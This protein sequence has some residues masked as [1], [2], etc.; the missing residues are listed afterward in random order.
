MEQG[1][2]ILQSAAR[3]EQALATCQDSEELR[4][5]LA[6]AAT[7]LVRRHR[8]SEAVR[9][10]DCLVEFPDLPSFAYCN[11]LWVAQ[12]DNTGLPVE[13]RRS[14]RYLAACLPYA[15][16]NPP[17]HLNAA[18]VFMELGETDAAL[19]QLLLAAS[20]RVDIQRHLAQPQLQP[21][22]AHPRWPELIA[23]QPPA[24]PEPS[25]VSLVQAA[26]AHGGAEDA[27]LPLLLLWRKTRSA[28]LADLI[29]RL[30][31]C[32]GRRVGYRA[33]WAER[34]VGDRPS[35]LSRLNRGSRVM[36]DGLGGYGN[37]QTK[38][39]LWLHKDCEDPR[40]ATA[41]V[42]LLR[43]PPQM[44]ASTWD[45][46][47]WQF[48]LETL[49]A[50]GDLRILDALE[51]LSAQV[52]ALLP[53][54]F[55]EWM[56]AKLRET[57][58]AL[59][60]QRVPAPL[61]SKVDALCA[62][63]EAALAMGQPP[64]RA[65]LPPPVEERRAA[66]DPVH[67]QGSAEGAPPLDMALEA[68]AAG[69]PAKAIPPLLREWERTRSPRLADL[70][71]LIDARITRVKRRRK[72]RQPR[73][74]QKDWI[75]L[76]RAN[77]P[78]DMPRLLS[79]FVCKRAP[80][81]A[82][83]L[84]VLQ[85]RRDPRLTTALMRLLEKP[86]FLCPLDEDGVEEFWNAVAEAFLHLGDVRAVEP[87]RAFSRRVRS[88]TVRCDNDA[89]DCGGSAPPVGGFLRRR[90]AETADALGASQGPKPLTATEE[91]LC[92]QMEALLEPE[93]QRMRFAREAA[94][95]K[96][97][98]RQDFLERIAQAPEDDEVRLAFAAWLQAHGEHSY[99]ELIRLQCLRT[100]GEAT[101][102]ALEREARL[103]DAAR[104]SPEVDVW[105]RWLGELAPEF[106][107]EHS[108]RGF[109]SVVRLSLDGELPAHLVGHPLWATVRRLKCSPEDWARREA[110]VELVGHPVMKSLRWLEGVT[111]RG[112][113]ELVRQQPRPYETVGLLLP[114]LEA[115]EWPLVLEALARLPKLRTLHLMLGPKDFQPSLLQPLLE[116][117]VGERVERLVLTVQ[118]E[119]APK[120]VAIHSA[121]EASPFAW[122]ELQWR[123]DFSYGPS[124]PEEV[125]KGLDCG[126]RFTRDSDGGLSCLRASHVGP[127]EFRMGQLLRAVNQLPAG[128][129]SCFVLAEPPAS[130]V[131]PSPRALAELK[132]LLR[133]FPRLAR[134]ELPS[135]EGT[136]RAVERLL[137]TLREERETWRHASAIQELAALGAA[138]AREPI[139]ERLRASDE[140]LQLTAAFALS[141]LAHASVVPFLRDAVHHPGCGKMAAL[142]LGSLQARE[143]VGELLWLLTHRKHEERRSEEEIVVALQALSMLGEPSAVP[144][145]QEFLAAQLARK[146]TERALARARLVAVDALGVLG[147]RQAR[148]LVIQALEIGDEYDRSS[149]VTA[150]GLVGSVDDIPLLQGQLGS[151]ERSSQ[152]R[153]CHSSRFSS[154]DSARLALL[155]L[156]PERLNS[157][158]ADALVRTLGGA[159]LLDSDS[160]RLL[161]LG[162]SLEELA[163]RVVEGGRAALSRGGDCWLQLCE[164]VERFTEER[165]EATR[166]A[167]LDAPHP[168]HVPAMMYWLGLAERIASRWAALRVLCRARA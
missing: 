151:E 164:A 19:L 87:L 162:R 140:W 144:E 126:L 101:A 42:R 15:N 58:S 56:G 69:R 142:T 152:S 117:R 14:R 2:F 120:W 8:Y 55:G 70:L 106:G 97:R 115:G 78:R 76:A 38:G 89:R 81:S 103:L 145:I 7:L 39:G 52:P 157:E 71:D 156:S 147:A 64:P 86:P 80:S 116:S 51:A 130:S 66:G 163:L 96:A 124:L 10:F 13:A 108:E 90:F 167:L 107:V 110:L 44:T 36:R 37:S 34:V 59:T 91:A 118:A 121:I 146:P 111:P 133:R 68:L 158:H 24:V 159:R 136:R 82:G 30:S 33:A 83:R 155:L 93:F 21:L 46:E 122:F 119:K 4:T 114:E 5:G 12:K 11:A 48:A 100:Q 67:S 99:G 31:E 60:A 131:Q 62:E 16:A 113:S 105:N 148:A 112:L 94:A 40:F 132:R 109:P 149:A 166:A 41:M 72:A 123:C 23:P 153:G 1:P 17:I 75:A 165:T 77:E 27:I 95:E 125:E 137:A 50:L 98:G 141:R 3:L 47:A 22:K 168:W 92:T 20:K 32:A 128:A 6:E 143:A 61:A 43:H 28:R 160:A 53:P 84:W 102:E 35:E 18:G 139:A 74:S 25:L 127:R 26:F 65:P 150:L 88:L 79:T 49:V 45:R 57:V 154:H 135:P 9:I 129:L 63:L 134:V 104:W 54:T 138:E 85:R 161:T 73:L 29:D